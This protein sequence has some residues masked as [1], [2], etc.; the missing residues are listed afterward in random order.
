MTFNESSIMDML[1][2]MK[3]SLIQFYIQGL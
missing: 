3:F 2:W 1:I